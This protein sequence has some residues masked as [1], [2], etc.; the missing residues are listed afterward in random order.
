MVQIVKQRNY[1]QNFL[2]FVSSFLITE[3]ASI[4]EINLIK[5]NTEIL[6]KRIEET[7]H[8]TTVCISKETEQNAKRFCNSN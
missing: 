8:K 5:A 3:S 7:E 2:D 1:I 4:S 6:L